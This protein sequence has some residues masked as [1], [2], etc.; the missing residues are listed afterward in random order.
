MIGN[1][2]ERPCQGKAA[3]SKTPGAAQAARYRRVTRK[4]THSVMALIR[5]WVVVTRAVV[6]GEI[7][8]ALVLAYAAMSVMRRTRSVAG[9]V[10]R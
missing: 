6:F 8:G 3:P 9:L 7:A 10:P 4:Q 1:S 5:C 2:T